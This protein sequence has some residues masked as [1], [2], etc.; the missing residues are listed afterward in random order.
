M[1]IQV[2]TGNEKRTRH[3]R[4]PNFPIAGTCKPYGLYPLWV[5]PV[6]PGETLQSMTTKIRALSMPIKHPLGGAW[7]ETWLVYVKF[8]NHRS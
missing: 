4:R 2:I 5:H 3:N 7:M 8:P 1:A 6:L